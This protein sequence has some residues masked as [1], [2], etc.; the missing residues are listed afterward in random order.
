MYNEKLDIFMCVADC[1]SFTKAAEKL[2]VSATAVMKQINL[3]ETHLGIKLFT[4]THHGIKLTYA[5]EA[6][7]RDA[8]F[9]K[10]FSEQSIAKAKALENSQRLT[11]R[12][13]TSMLNPC[14]VFMDLWNEISSEFPQ[15]KI[16]I[17]PFED[18][19]NNILSV[20]DKI[21]TEIDFIVGV[22]DS[23][24]WLSRCNFLKLGTY[25]KCVAIPLTHPLSKRKNIKI[26]DLYGETLMMV[27]KG[28]SALNDNIRND[29]TKNHPL[30]KI[31]DTPSFYDI[32]VYNRCAEKGN[33]LLNI[34][35]WKDIHPSFVTLPVE[36]DYKIPYGLLYSKTPEEHITQFLSS[37]MKTRK[38]ENPNTY[39]EQ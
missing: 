26:K 34:E 24:L 21:G 19:H 1:G 4:R 2:Y 32:G 14:K 11:I 20:I 18:D 39:E 27:E 31:E 36:W 33:I 17:I 5:G 3:L 23:A 9:L 29:L 35:C 8:R 25:K 37:V 15:F 28:D 22:C 6:I 10:S 13:G 12:I 38:E 16:K 7:Y 30:I